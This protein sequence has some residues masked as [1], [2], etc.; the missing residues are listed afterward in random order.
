MPSGKQQGRSRADAPDV[1]SHDAAL[2]KASVHTLLVVNRPNLHSV[3]TAAQSSCDL[4]RVARQSSRK[5]SA[6]LRAMVLAACNCT[7]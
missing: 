3:A 6:P 7:S 5:T 1:T 2:R 4:N